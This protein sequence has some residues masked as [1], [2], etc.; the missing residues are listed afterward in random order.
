MTWLVIPKLK[1]DVGILHLNETIVCGRLVK[2][3][4]DPTRYDGGI[5]VT[6]VQ[7]QSLNINQDLDTVALSHDVSYVITWDTI[8]I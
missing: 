4:R 1:L 5:S 6:S 2:G 8:L 3:G 7:R